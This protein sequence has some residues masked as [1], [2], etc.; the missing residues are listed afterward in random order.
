MPGEDRASAPLVPTVFN[1]RVGTFFLWS[2]AS[3]KPLRA[4]GVRP[5]G[6]PN[7]ECSAKP[8]LDVR[9]GASACALLGLP[10]I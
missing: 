1:A 4:S 5:S 2:R 9:P 10:A 6:R 3:R 8:P 7:N